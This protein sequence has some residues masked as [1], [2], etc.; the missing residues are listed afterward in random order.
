M[1]THDDADARRSWRLVF[2][3]VHAAFAVMSAS[4][5]VTAIWQRT[6]VK[7]TLFQGG[8]VYDWGL[9]NEQVPG[10]Q[11]MDGWGTLGRLSLLA[12]GIYLAALI[13]RGDKRVLKYYALYGV[14]MI[15]VEAVVNMYQIELWDMPRGTPSTW[16]ASHMAAYAAAMVGWVV[17]LY[18]SRRARATFVHEPRA[19]GPVDPTGRLPI[20]LGAVALIVWPFVTNIFVRTTPFARWIS[21]K[22]LAAGE[23]FASGILMMSVATGLFVLMKHAW[24]MRTVWV[25]VLLPVG[26]GV[27]AL[28]YTMQS[29]ALHWTF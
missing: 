13:A 7:P 18:L 6:H 4:A 28:L 22:D 21:P 14:A 10:V 29:F 2:V 25:A 9:S 20:G 15:A 27:L 3:L 24:H 17:Y 1:P 26:F 19:T 12:A 11:F 23:G 8:L 16:Y 5:L